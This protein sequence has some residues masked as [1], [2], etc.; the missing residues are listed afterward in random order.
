MVERIRVAVVDDHP[1]CLAGVT[2]FV[3]DN[4][5]FELVAQGASGADAIEIARGVPADVLLLDIDLPGGGIEATRTITTLRT[6]IKV[7]LLTASDRQEHVTAAL[8]AGARGYVLKGVSS[9][10]LAPVIQSVS[11][12]ATYVTPGLATRLLTQMSRHKTTSLKADLSELTPRE[13]Q[14]LERIAGGQTNKETAFALKISDKTVKHYMTN[15]MQ[16]LNVRNRVEAALALQRR[17]AVSRPDH[18]S[19]PVPGK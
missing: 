11:N 1:I 4:D 12:G 8:A 5:V 3:R 17:K 13:E 10:E 19:R 9:G 7:I 18:L 6:D 14:I 2:Q 16:K 15:I